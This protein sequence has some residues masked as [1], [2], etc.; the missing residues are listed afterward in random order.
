MSTCGAEILDD[1]A[2]KLAAEY[3]ARGIADM[4]ARQLAL[5]TCECIRQD[6]GGQMI[7]VPMGRRSGRDAE[8]R[9]RWNGRNMDELCREF[10]LSE[11]QVRR[12]LKKSIP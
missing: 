6:W 4:L 12:I 8:I 1:L 9:R 7:Y 2:A 5:A 10:Q 11:I 3:I